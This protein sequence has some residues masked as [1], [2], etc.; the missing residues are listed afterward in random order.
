VFLRIFW[1]YLRLWFYLFVV[2]GNLY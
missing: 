2:G 1:K